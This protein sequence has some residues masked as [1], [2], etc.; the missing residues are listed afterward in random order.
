MRRHTGRPWPP[1]ERAREQDPAKAGEMYPLTV[2]T[3]NVA[4]F[5]RFELALL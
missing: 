2:V 4:D 1:I 5:S 3:R